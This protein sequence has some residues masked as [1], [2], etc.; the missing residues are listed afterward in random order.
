MLEPSGLRPVMLIVPFLRPGKNESPGRLL[1][2]SD[3]SRVLTKVSRARFTML[4]EMIRR[5]STVA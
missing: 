5:S 2:K 1:F 3:A 4:E